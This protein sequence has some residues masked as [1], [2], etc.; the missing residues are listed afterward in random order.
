MTRTP[1]IVIALIVG[2]LAPALHAEEESPDMH[3]EEE[4]PDM[5]AEEESPD[6]AEVIPFKEG[7]VISYEDVG[8]LKPYLPKEFWNNRDFFFYEGMQ[9]EIGPNQADYSPADVY[10]AATEK[11]RG[12]PRI[13]PD[14]SLENYTAGQPFPMDEIDCLGDPDAGTKIMHNH[15]YQ[16]RGAATH[17]R[18]YYSYWDRGEEL[19]LYYEGHAEGALLSNRP[20]PCFRS[21]RG[22]RV[23]WRKAE[24]MP[25]GLL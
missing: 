7:D 10:K 21:E 4:S 18:F 16:W 22:R 17:T 6:T 15:S 19:P 20:E 9:L 23:P 8:K 12:Q 24:K 13:G 3:A 2:L 11:Y 14:D 5:H 1:W 25:A